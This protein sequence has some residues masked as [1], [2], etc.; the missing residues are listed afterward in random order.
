MA[1]EVR[2]RKLAYQYPPT[3][4]ISFDRIRKGLDQFEC[5]G[6]EIDEREEN[7]T[8]QAFNSGGRRQF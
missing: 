4:L 8:L 5:L 7:Q 6:R 2:I 1:G 3:I